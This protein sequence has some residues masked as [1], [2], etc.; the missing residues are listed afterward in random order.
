MI[1]NSPKII[2]VDC[3]NTIIGRR[4][5][6]NDV[7]LLWGKKLEERYPQISKNEFFKMFKKYWE[8]LSFLDRIGIENSEFLTD[9]HEIF[10][11]MAGDISKY[12]LINNFNSQEF[13][14][15]A[16]EAYI[17]AEHECHYLKPRVIKFLKKA[18]AK[19][20][21]IFIV[22]DFYCEASVIKKWLTLLH[23]DVD[24]L[25]DKIYVSCEY[26]KSKATGSLYEYILKENNL[27]PKDVT[28]IGDN[29]ISDRKMAKK[30][31][32]K[33]KFLALPQVKSDCKDIRKAKEKLTIPTE[34]LDIFNESTLAD[35]FYPNYAFP[36]YAFTKRLF[37]ECE[38]KQIKNLFFLA[39]E[40]KFLKKLFDYYCTYNNYNIKTHYFAVSRASAIVTTEK[41]YEEA[42]V[43]LDDK[44]FMI[45]KNFLKTLHFSEEEI[46]EICKDAKI[47]PNKINIIFKN[48]R[49]HKKILKSPAF[50]KLYKKVHTE[51]REAY[52]KYINSFNVDLKKEG[53]YVVDSGWRGNMQRYMKNYF[54]H[55]QKMEGFYIGTAYK[56]CAKEQVQG[57]LFSNK[58]KKLGWTN[59]IFSYRRFNYEEILRAPEATCLAY[60]VKTGEPI[61]ANKTAETEAYDKTIKPMQDKIF[62][63]FKRIVDVDS[64]IYSNIHSVC[65]YM[66]FKL[67]KKSNKI[68]VKFFN[69]AQNSFCDSFGYVGYSYKNI[70]AFLRVL[71]FKAKDLFYIIRNTHAVNKKRKYWI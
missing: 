21:K 41:P 23:L 17:S 60:D 71:N 53:F 15:I 36:L 3:F 34:Y 8:Q 47:R 58:L 61:L 11:K 48:S 62:E 56:N 67:I 19:N 1:K 64:K 25:I 24:A 26:K 6:P 65:A 4:K 27:N 5:T 69:E 68:D 31:G 63:K 55:P 37:E 45:T 28:M 43:G 39:R 10:L 66:M 42:F 20:H 9:I 70:S 29:L 16:M 14:E 40:G 22:S 7:I 32:L 13:M 33:V 52:T 12:K 54:S 57:L 49:T 30:A 50:N 44:V 46:K 51:Q 38:R 35:G 18:K 2:F 59:K